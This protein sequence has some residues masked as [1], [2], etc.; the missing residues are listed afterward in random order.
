MNPV[1]RALVSV[2]DKA[3][4]VDFCKQLVQLNITILS[5]G[6]TARLLAENG[7]KVVEVSDYTGS[8]EMMDGRVKTL[9]PK[10]HGGLLGRRGVDDAVMKKHGIEPIDLV[11]VN[12]YPFEQT[13]SRPDCTLTEAIENIDI[14]GPTMLRSAAKNYASVGVV[15][16]VSDYQ[17]VLAELQANR[18][19]LSDETR[20][21]LAQKVFAH[22]ANYDA[23][24]SNYL[25]SIGKDGAHLDFPLTYT[26]QFR[27][28]QELRYGE[29]P[30]QK[31]AFYAQADAPAGTTLPPREALREIIRRS[32]EESREMGFYPTRPAT[33]R[34]PAA[35]VAEAKAQYGKRN[36]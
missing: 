32:Q 6:G 19:T 7:V 33:R 22:T 31:A 18:C 3:G 15:V 36:T 24:V 16:D 25:G 10:I 20:F 26:S 2:S 14:G 35:K 12:L 28:L 27:K 13:V 8:P 30:H 17:R 1:K 5:T 4:I 21:S 23:N 9:H 34:Q 29:N 11:V